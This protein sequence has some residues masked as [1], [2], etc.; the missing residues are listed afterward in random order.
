[1]ALSRFRREL[2]GLVARGLSVGPLLLTRARKPVVVA[3]P[4]DEYVRLAELLPPKPAGGP[5]PDL[6][7][8]SREGSD[9]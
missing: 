4:Y 2:N 3:M 7:R 1:M 5:A 8:D 9:S 6:D